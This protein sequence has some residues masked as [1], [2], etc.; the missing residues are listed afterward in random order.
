MALAP[1]PVQLYAHVSDHLV[2]SFLY[3][4]RDANLLKFVVSPT[5]FPVFKDKLQTSCFSGAL[6]RMG[7]R[8]EK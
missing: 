6:M 3:S 2:N 8:G 5:T 1:A 4:L 7:L